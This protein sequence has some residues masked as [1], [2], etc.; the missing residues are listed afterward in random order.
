[1]K[2]FKF[3]KPRQATHRCQ[4]FETDNDSYRFKANSGFWQTHANS[5]HL[6]CPH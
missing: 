5:S 4:I 6:E 2:A 3:T 1:M